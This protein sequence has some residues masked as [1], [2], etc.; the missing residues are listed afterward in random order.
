[1]YTKSDI[2]PGWELPV[3]WDWDKFLEWVNM[4]EQA[5]WSIKDAY[6][7]IGGPVVDG[8]ERQVSERIEEF[9]VIGTD[10]EPHDLAMLRNMARA[11]IMVERYYVLIEQTESMAQIKAYTDAIERFQKM[12]DAAQKTLRIDRLSRQ[13]DAERDK[14]EDKSQIVINEGGQWILDHSIQ[15]EHCERLLGWLVLNFREVT[16]QVWTTCPVCGQ[17]VSIHYNPTQVAD[18]PGWVKE[19]ESGEDTVLEAVE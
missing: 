9:K 18:V 3:G 16:T 10:W 8:F 17:E 7:S 15:I 19:E 12:I 11:S 14:N 2:D 4:P 6:E 1:M 5:G 13:S